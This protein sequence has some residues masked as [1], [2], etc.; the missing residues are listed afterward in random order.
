MN[1]AERK[2]R[3]M[4]EMAAVRI[5]TLRRLDS[6]PDEL[7][8]IRVHDFY[9]PLGWHFGHIGMTEESWTCH[10][11]L[12]Q[13]CLDKALSFLFAN[14]D[15]NPKEQR[16]HLPDRAEI[17]AYLAAT[18]QQALAGLAEADLENAAPL[19]AD[20][21]AWEFALQHECQHQE[22]ISELMQLVYQS[23]PGADLEFSP[24][25]PDFAATGMD[26][27]AGGMCRIGS[28]NAHVYDNEKP[29]YPVDV[30]P[31]LIDVSPATAA[32][33]V[34][35][36][37]DGGYERP[38]VWSEAGWA[39]R[40]RENITMPEYWRRSEAGFSC[41]SAH[42]LRPIAPEE[43]ACSL[44]WFEADAF[45]RWAGKRLPTEFEWECAARENPNLQ[46]FGSIWQWTSSAFLPYPGFVAF[47]YDGYSKEHMDG[48]HK[49]CRGSSWASDPRRIARPSFRNW[50]IPSYRQGFLG[51]RCAR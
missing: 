48:K 30:A 47:P 14:L 28:N 49:V 18:R 32:Q 24:L 36:I 38:G 2:A 50:Y 39:W 10:Q 8:K 5:K 19:L 16:V 6:V 25:E 44:S 34:A 33:W 27:I 11:A 41:Y 43:P 17:I 45:A 29:E 42:G 21:Y 23:L 1:Q 3:I 15:E 40:Q 37:A 13:E 51:V 46:M 9:S 20:G 31:F 7:L 12:G 26:A 35:F 4:R 22:T